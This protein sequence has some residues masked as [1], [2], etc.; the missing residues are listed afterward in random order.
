V[1]KFIEPEASDQPQPG[2]SATTHPY[3]PLNPTALGDL[4]D[5]FDFSRGPRND[6][7][8]LSV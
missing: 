5:T 8:L 7:G 2:Q 3:V 6:L 4:F 1:L